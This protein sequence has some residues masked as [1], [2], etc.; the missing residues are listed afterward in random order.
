MVYDSIVMIHTNT[1]MVFQASLLGMS[2][3]IVLCIR[4]ITVHDI[5]N[6]F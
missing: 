1:C 6:V 5:Y 4:A 3:N 2:L